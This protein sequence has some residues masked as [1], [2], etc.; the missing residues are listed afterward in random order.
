MI[1][2]VREHFRNLLVFTDGNEAIGQAVE[3]TTSKGTALLVGNR[4]FIRSRSRS[5]RVA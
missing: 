1:E 5:L 3:F 2:T 4:C